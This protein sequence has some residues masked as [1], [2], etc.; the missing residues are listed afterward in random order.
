MRSFSVVI[1]QAD[2][3]LPRCVHILI[4]GT[5]TLTLHSKAFADITRFRILKLGG[6]AGLYGEETDIIMIVSIKEKQSGL[7]EACVMVKTEVRLIQPQLKECSR[8]P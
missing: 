3:R 8:I 2:Q 6:Y 1:H 7:R 4:P 5:V